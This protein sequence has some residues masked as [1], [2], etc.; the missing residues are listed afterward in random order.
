M[1]R[2]PRAGLRMAKVAQVTQETQARIH[3]CL[4]AVA[5]ERST[6]SIRCMRMLLRRLLIQLC[7]ES[8]AS[9]SRALSKVSSSRRN[10]VE[11][12]SSTMRSEISH[13]SFA[14]NPC[15]WR[16]IA[17]PLGFFVAPG[18]GAGKLRGRFR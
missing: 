11:K 17:L 4:G 12:P 13:A 18:H 3:A 2:E 10:V 7:T 15:R 5:V 8:P 14:G 16:K 9:D 1:L 6:G